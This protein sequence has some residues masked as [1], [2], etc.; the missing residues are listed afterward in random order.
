MKICR[1]ILSGF[2]MVLIFS[3][4]TQGAPFVFSGKLDAPDFNQIKSVYPNGGY[5][6]CV[7]SSDADGVVW[8]HNHGFDL[9]PDADQEE[10]IVTDLASLMHTDPDHGTYSGNNLQGMRDYLGS[11]YDPN[12]IVVGSLDLWDSDQQL[13]EEKWQRVEEY[14]TRPDTFVALW[15]TGYYQGYC[16]GSHSVFLA[17]YDMTDYESSNEFKI[18]LHDPMLGPTESTDTY[19]LDLLNS[20]GLYGYGTNEYKG[21]DFF[22]TDY[23]T[24]SGAYYFQIVPEPASMAMLALGGLALLRRR[25]A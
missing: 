19:T 12:D 15:G 3:P 24:L 2:V 7:P 1:W 14:V 16:V 8:L 6:Y 9:L 23:V 10:T 17:G 21:T 18:S 5:Y 13:L 11:F 4:V 22:P 25:K 20:G